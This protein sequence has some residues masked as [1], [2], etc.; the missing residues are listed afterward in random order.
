MEKTELEKLQEAAAT[1]R[2]AAAEAAEKASAKNAS[3]ASKEE[4][5]RLAKLAEEADQR[6]AEE[7]T[8]LANEAEQKKQVDEAAS[9]AAA[10]TG[11][12]P[13][14]PK[15]VNEDES[16]QYVPVFLDEDGEKIARNSI[17][18][19]CTTG[20]FNLRSLD[21]LHITSEPTAELHGP[22]VKDGDWYTAQFKAGLLRVDSVKKLR[23]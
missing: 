17:L 15:K 12:T 19:I 14:P 9:L 10:Q 6:V 5:G 23:S 8:R 20:D 18:R 11:E 7:E 3:N 13:K 21:G 4:A 16:A 2:A 1:A 22:N